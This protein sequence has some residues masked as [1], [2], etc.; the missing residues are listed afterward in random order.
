M[1]ELTKKEVHLIYLLYFAKVSVSEVAQLC[2]CS[3]RTVQG[4][5]KRI[6]VKLNQKVES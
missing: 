2:E 5:H 1:K 3:R 6:F 4:R